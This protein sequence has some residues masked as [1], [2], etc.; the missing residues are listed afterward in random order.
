MSGILFGFGYL[1]SFFAMLNYISDAYRQFS[2]PAQAAASTIRSIAAVGLPFAS[3]PMAKSLGVGWSCS[4][5]G[6]VTLAMTPIPFCF[7]IYGE[8]IRA[9]SPFCQKLSG[10]TSQSQLA[11]MH[12]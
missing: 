2:A 1:I 7:I 3:A 8:T 6:F 10:G 9:R 12:P 4:L 11:D 5:L